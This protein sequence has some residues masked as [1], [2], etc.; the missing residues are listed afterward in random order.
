MMM[1]GE[2]VQQGSRPASTGLCR[3]WPAAVAS[4]PD[5]FPKGSFHRRA[6]RRRQ[7]A[8]AG[9]RLAMQDG[10]GHASS[11]SFVLRRAIQSA[12]PAGQLVASRSSR[13]SSQRSQNEMH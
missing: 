2:H 6:E 1:L 13:P 7:P 11:M 12:D 3:D 9:G 5:L 8:D 10:H 4:Q